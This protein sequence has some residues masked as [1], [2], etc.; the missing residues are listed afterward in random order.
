M[1][2]LLPIHLV[3]TS[4]IYWFRPLSRDPHFSLMVACNLVMV[5]LHALH[6]PSGRSVFKAIYFNCALPNILASMNSQCYRAFNPTYMVP[7]TIGL[8]RQ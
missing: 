7:I 6:R 8:V 3:I 1:N 4:T 5:L 2:S